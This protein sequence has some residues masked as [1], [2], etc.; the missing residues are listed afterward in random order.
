MFW[1]CEKSHEKS[2]FGIAFTRSRTPSVVN[3]LIIAGAFCAFV[4]QRFEQK[5]PVTSPT[6]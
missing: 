2:A 5:S 3:I 1:V 6:A 4:I